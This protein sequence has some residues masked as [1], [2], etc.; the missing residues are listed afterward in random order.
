MKTE[1]KY[2]VADL[3]HVPNGLFPS[4]LDIEFKLLSELHGATI[5]EVGWITGE[6]EGGFCIDYQHD[7][8]P[9]KR[10]VLGYN[11][12]GVWIKWHGEKNED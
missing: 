10:I 8:S 7:D 4:D 1:K 11:D 3:A 5:K 9:V 2:A 12:L 6:I